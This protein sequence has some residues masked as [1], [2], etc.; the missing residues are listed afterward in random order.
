MTIGDQAFCGTPDCPTFLWH[1]SMTLDE[2]MSDISFVDLRR[3][4]DR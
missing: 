4:E 3:E 2:L 1:L